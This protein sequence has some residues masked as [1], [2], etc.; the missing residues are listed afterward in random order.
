MHQNE[1]DKTRRTDTLSRA[2]RGLGLNMA[3]GLAEVGLRGI[4]ILDVQQ[5]IGDKCARELTE[6]TGVDT[7]FY[8][9]DVRDGLAIGQTIQDIVRHYGDLNIL[10]NAAGIAE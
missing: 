4:A 2:G 6:Q 3:Q 8:R 7:R 10:V 9:V 1:P 5:E